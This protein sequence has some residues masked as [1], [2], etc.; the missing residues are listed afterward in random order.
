MK[1]LSVDTSTRRREKQEEEPLTVADKVCYY[2]HA[3]WQGM[4]CQDE[5]T[6]AM[7][8]PTRLGAARRGGAGQGTAR[9]GVAR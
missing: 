6:R 7:A 3:T 4:S 9:P 1:R 8:R 2:T 5:A